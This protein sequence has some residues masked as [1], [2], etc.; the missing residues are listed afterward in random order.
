MSKSVLNSREQKKIVDGLVAQG[1][2]VVRG[3]NG[4][5]TLKFVDGDAR[6]VNLATGD[7]AGIVNTRVL[8]TRK[9]GLRW[10]LD[11][12]PHVKRPPI[13]GDREHLVILDEAPPLDSRNVLGEASTLA[14][15]K[16]LGIPTGITFSDTE[17][18]QLI[19]ERVD[20]HVRAMDAPI[21][22]RKKAT[23]PAKKVKT[24]SSEVLSE[25]IDLTP[26]LA[27]QLLAHNTENRNIRKPHVRSL[28]RDMLQG[29]WQVTGDSIK[30]DVNDR[31]IDGQHRCWAV[32]ES[33][34][35]IKALLVIG[36]Q[37]E[38]REV[39]DTNARRSS[40]DALKFAGH[41]KNT[42]TVAAAARIAVGRM[43]GH[44]ST[45][46]DASTPKVTNSEVVAWVEANP[47][48]H[49]AV[50]LGRKTERAIGI[51]AGPWAYC[52]WEL[53]RIDVDEATEF[54]LS[55]AE[56]RTDGAGDPRAALLTAVQRARASRRTLP[57]AEVIFI[58]FRV[59]NAWRTNA[60]VKR[61]SPVAGRADSG[62]GVIPNPL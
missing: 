15:K 47:D 24:Q 20:P 56:F 61:I 40:A 18:L 60:Q 27:E 39:I 54:A 45:A 41:D 1:V 8:V 46:L 21:S 35:T 33:G 62:G 59:W 12:E 4:R 6:T 22:S 14:E 55:L 32:I 13:R 10:P 29:R 7:Q 52:L 36:L 19:Q 43:T 51:P 44:F 42:F 9:H 31:M 57:T 30:I 34:V 58:V 50:S 48:I 23:V 49:S 37:P 17:G 28:A 11:P 53:R 5:V 3:I 16:A 2:T 26:A 38:A 25:W